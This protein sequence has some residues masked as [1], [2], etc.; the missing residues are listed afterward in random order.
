MNSLRYRRDRYLRAGRQ[1]EPLCRVP[2]FTA[3]ETSPALS[4]YDDELA[5]ATAPNISR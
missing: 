4:A 3:M 1:A 2:P 5:G